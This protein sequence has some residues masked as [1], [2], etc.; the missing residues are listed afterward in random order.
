MQDN[1]LQ[2]VSYQMDEVRQLLIAK[3]SKV[4]PTDAELMLFIRTAENI[5][6]DLVRGDIHLVKY[7]DSAPASII[8]GKDYF[9]KTA[10]GLGGSWKAGLIIQRG[11]QIIEEIG[12]FK[13][14]TDILLGGWAEVKTVD[15]GEFKSRVSLEEYSSGQSTWKKMPAT[16]I[17][18]VA[19]MHSLRE[20]YPDR[21][22]G[23]YD[24]SEMQQAIPQVD[25]VNAVEERPVIEAP[26]QPT[27]IVTAPVQEIVQAPVQE[28]VQTPS[29]P[30]AQ[31]TSVALAEA[32]QSI[33]CPINGESMNLREGQYGQYYSHKATCMGKE[34][35]NNSVEKPS[36]QHKDA[37]LT[38]VNNKFGTEKATLV[39]SQSEGQSITWWLSQLEEPE[40]QTCLSCGDVADELN[41]E[42]NMMYC[43]E[44]L[45][46]PKV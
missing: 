44:C 7:S 20:A 31:T 30:I 28:V 27:K 18:K 6:A 19:L 21:F 46:N 16:M 41:P 3:G 10:R 39:E 34:W 14:K 36:Q 12:E 13:L 22:R 43:L 26:K 9:T 45:N 5:G 23:V 29:Q 35:C 17:R 24:S 25:L 8:T 40:E 33:M 32:P 1:S 15:G 4:Q 38:Q 42:D 11:D 2:T 37:W